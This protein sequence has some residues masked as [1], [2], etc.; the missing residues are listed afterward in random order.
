MV[1]RN[2]SVRTVSFQPLIN[3]NFTKIM[4]KMVRIW[5][6]FGGIYCYSRNF[7]VTP[8]ASHTLSHLHGV[9]STL[10]CFFTKFA[11]SKKYDFSGELCK[12]VFSG[13]RVSLFFWIPIF[14]RVSNLIFQTRKIVLS[15]QVLVLKHLRK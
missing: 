4:F 5:C 13:W 9:V 6:K 14:S 10:L 7:P 3:T 8:A 15:Q 11:S 12:S 1:F 2:A